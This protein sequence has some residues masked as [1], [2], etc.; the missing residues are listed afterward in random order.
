[1]TYGRQRQEGFS[2]RQTLVETDSTDVFDDSSEGRVIGTELASSDAGT[3]G[4]DF[5][6]G[7]ATD[8]DRQRRDQPCGAVVDLA[9]GV[10]SIYRYGYSSDEQSWGAE[11][12]PCG[13][14]PQGDAR[15]SERLGQSL[16]GT[17]LEC[18]VDVRTA[19]NERDVVPEIKHRVVSS[20]SRS[21][22]APE[23]LISHL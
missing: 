8:T 22:V 3:S 20:W 10:F 1:M 15:Y 14:G 17:V 4:V 12:S 23:R 5:A 9:G 6:R 13:A 11:Y 2:L 16:V 19:R 7:M 18:V 21:A